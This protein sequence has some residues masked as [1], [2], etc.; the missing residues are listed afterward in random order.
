MKPIIKWVGGKTQLLEELK[1][2]ITPELLAGHTYYEPFIGGGA[3]AFDLAHDK[4]VINDFNS[5]LT[6][7][8]TVVK[9][10]LLMLTTWL[11]I[12]AQGYKDQG[13]KFFYDV[14][15][16]DR[17]PD[18]EALPDP[19]LAAR[20]VF[21]NKTCFNGLYRVNRKGYFNSPIG[22]TA[23]GK[24][25]KLYDENNLISLSKW[26]KGHC[27]IRNGSYESA[28]SDAK[29]GDVIY[30][31]PPYDQ[32]ESIE[33]EGFVG[34]VSEGWTWRDTAHLKA[35]C[36]K[37]VERGCSVIISNNDTKLVRELF[38][39]YEIKSVEVKRSVNRDGSKRKGQEVIIYK[40][41]K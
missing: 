8:Y 5:E 19:Q 12:M 33:S 14:R 7:L 34:Y 35:V 4:T 1:Q 15:E 21:L 18:F 10:N 17:K 26:M 31:D 32:D 27:A 2:I 24:A 13:A 38:A 22:R 6:R 28:V 11:N 16:W 41:A 3:L 25:P 40:L 20:T 29:A 36:D 39:D 9:T 30:F 23:S 37:L